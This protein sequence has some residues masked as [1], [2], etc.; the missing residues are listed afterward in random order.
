MKINELPRAGSYE[1]ALTQ[2]Q[3]ISLHKLLL[4]RASLTELWEK[5]LPW[6][7]GPEQGR[8]PSKMCLCRIQRRLLMEEEVRGIQSTEAVSRATQ[9][10]MRKTTDKTDQ[11]KVLDRAISLIGQQVIHA[12]R[13]S[14][15][16]A[17]NISAATRL[18]LQHEKLRLY[19]ER[20]AKMDNDKKKDVPPPS[21]ILSDEEKERRWRAIFGMEPLS[22]SPA[23]GVDL[24]NYDPYKD[25]QLMPN[26]DPDPNLNPNPDPGIDPGPESESPS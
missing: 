24:A 13:K 17:P 4:S 14:E 1:A 23:E 7:Q 19:A 26:P 21:P 12:S 9:S 6:P 5:A 20:T 8:K 15:D 10:L 25:P 16:P 11:K 3:R 22:K 18:L 2:D